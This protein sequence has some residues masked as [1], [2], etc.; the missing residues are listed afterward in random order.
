MITIIIRFYACNSITHTSSCC[1][2]TKDP[3]PRESPSFY[4]CSV[5]GATF[6]VNY[7][8]W[9]LKSLFFESLLRGRGSATI[10]VNQIVFSD[11]RSSAVG[12][13]DFANQ[14]LSSQ[15]FDLLFPG[16]L[17]HFLCFISRPEA[18]VVELFIRLFAEFCPAA[19]ISL[20]GR[21]KW[22]GI[23]QLQRRRE[24]ME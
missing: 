12:R 2:G 23:M 17:H 9:G 22:T 24:G 6:E 21:S 1:D 11:G 4:Y 13:I 20:R 14:Q 18:T 10:A 8:Y 5:H 7:I 3:L 15:P 19:L 16:R